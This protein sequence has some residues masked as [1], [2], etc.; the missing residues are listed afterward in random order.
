V[1]QTIDAL[2][3]TVENMLSVMSCNF[4][5]DILDLLKEDTAAI[6]KTDDLTAGRLIMLLWWLRCML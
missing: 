3:H 5:E 6:A 1:C 4:I 2:E